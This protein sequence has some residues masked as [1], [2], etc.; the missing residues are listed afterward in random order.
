MSARVVVVVLLALAACGPSTAAEGVRASGG[1]DPVICYRVNKG[2]SACRDGVGSFW[3]CDAVAPIDCVR[4]EEPAKVFA[5]PEQP[6]GS[7]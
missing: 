5:L 7:P 1:V 4:A 6:A 2:L 3:V